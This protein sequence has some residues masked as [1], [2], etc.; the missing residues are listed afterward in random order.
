MKDLL[1]RFDNY[2]L[3]LM[4]STIKNRFFDFFFPKFTNL[5]GGKGMTLLLVIWFL[6][7]KDKYMKT[8]IIEAG[9]LQIL[10]GMIVH[11]IKFLAKRVRPYDL[12]KDLNT[13][14]IFLWDYSF[15][16]GHTASSVSLLVVASFY[17]PDYILFFGIFAI[18]MGMSRMYLGVHYPTDVLA[19]AF[20][21][22]I[23][24]ILGHKFISPFVL[25][26]LTKILV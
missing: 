22:W 16:S 4:N 23:V 17:Y 18:L 13:F 3:K 26:N 5:G 25:E 12:L 8:F 19:G 21:G 11:T 14:D 9:L 10:T 20:T 2:V 6:F 7:A 15:P 24:T 1:R